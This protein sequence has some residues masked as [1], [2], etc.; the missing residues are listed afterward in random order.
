[1][2]RAKAAAGQPGGAARRRVGRKC[3][4]IACC[5]GKSWRIGK[6]GSSGRL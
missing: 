2:P 5:F 1:M 3:I 6:A 4:F